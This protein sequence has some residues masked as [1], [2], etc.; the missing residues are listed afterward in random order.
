VGLGL[1]AR[2]GAT[3]TPVPGER[4]VRLEAE[5]YDIYFELPG[6]Y[7]KYNEFYAPSDLRVSIAPLGERSL[8]LAGYSGLS[9]VGSTGSQGLA[10]YTVEIP[11][12]GIYRIRT[13][14]PGGALNRATVVLGVLPGSAYIRLIVAGVIAL[15]A[16]ITLCVLGPGTVSMLR[17]AGQ[18]GAS[19]APATSSF[20]PSAV[21]MQATTLGFVASTVPTT[22]VSGVPGQHVERLARL[23][24]L[25]DQGAVTAGEFEAQKR[26]ILSDG[27]G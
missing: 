10:I 25:R 12:D 22:T 15:L 6:D 1:E 9:Y 19:G 2:I 5:K 11:Q 16:F 4:A 27:N 14:W 3:R 17:S 24:A 13:Q 21:A 8:P 18:T 7:N 23:V 20:T 26:R